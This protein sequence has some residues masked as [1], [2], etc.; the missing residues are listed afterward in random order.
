MCRNRLRTRSRSCSTPSTP[1]WAPGWARADVIGAYAGLRPLVDAGEGRTADISR[2]HAIIESGSGVFSII[3]GK[4]TEYRHM[5]EDVLDRAVE[6][7][8]LTA[9]PCR[10]RN[11]PLVGAPANP[12]PPRKPA[13]CRARWSPATARR[14]RTSSPRRLAS[15]PTTRW[16]TESTSPEPNSSTRSRHEGALDVDDILDRRTRI[17]LG[18]GRPRP[19]GGRGRGVRSHRCAR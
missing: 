7:R 13:A 4:L 12:G 17:G 16:P 14:R 1:R 11:L 19:R 9:G 5:A 18:R 6:S 8:G 2:D 10:T 15:A 3:G